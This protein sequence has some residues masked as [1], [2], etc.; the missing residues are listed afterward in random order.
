[1][2]RTLTKP[3]SSKT[4]RT[5]SFTLISFMAPWIAFIFF[6]EKSNTRKAAE[7]SYRVFLHPENLL[8]L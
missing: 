3:V 4:S 2:L 7:E 6:W 8:C 5:V 1:M